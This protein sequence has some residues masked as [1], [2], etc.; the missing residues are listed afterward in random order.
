MGWLKA[1]REEILGIADR[2]LVLCEGCLTAE[3]S[4]AEAR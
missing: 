3:F 4:R 1:K 2:V